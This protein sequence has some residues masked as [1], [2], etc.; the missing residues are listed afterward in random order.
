MHALASTQRIVLRSSE[1][2]SL[3]ALHTPL[4]SEIPFATLFNLAPP[5]GNATFD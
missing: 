5:E 1:K 3:D 4:P 2:S